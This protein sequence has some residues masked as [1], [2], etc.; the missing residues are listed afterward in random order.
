MVPTVSEGTSILRP[1]VR[2]LL[3]FFLM[4]YAQLSEF[5][6]PDD[7]KHVGCC[8]EDFTAAIALIEEVP[9]KS[10]ALRT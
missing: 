5:K 9:Q 6:D 7:M 2:A 8:A 3:N 10:L 1:E 4:N